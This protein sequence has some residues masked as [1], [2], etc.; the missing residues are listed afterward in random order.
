[1][2][3]IFSLL[4]LSLPIFA[5]G[6]NKEDL[7]YEA[8]VYQINLGQSAS[9][10][11]IDV[12]DNQLVNDEKT[13]RVYHFDYIDLEGIKELVLPTSYQLNFIE[14]KAFHVR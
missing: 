9:T 4:I 5:F 2:K 3:L 7:Q 13:I 10:S 1:M 8:A 12:I 6:Q 14:A 11:D